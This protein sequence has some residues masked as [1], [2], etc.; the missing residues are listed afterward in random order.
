MSGEPPRALSSEPPRALGGEPASTGAWRVVTRAARD[1][2]GEGLLWSPRTQALF[3]T[4]IIGRKLWR[5]QP[6][7]GA[8]DH[9]DCPEMIGWVVERAGGG[10]VAGLQSGFHHLDLDP[11]RLAPIADPEPSLPGNRLNDAK[12][13]ERG[14]IWAGTMPV[15]DGP[16]SGWPASGG[17]YRLDPD[18][19]VTQHDRGLTIANGPAFSPDGGLLYHT[20]SARGVVYRFALAADGHLGRRQVHLTFDVATGAPDGMTCDRDGGLWI[21]FYG[22]SR[23]SRFHPDGRLDRS[24]AL[25]TPQLTN[26]VF[27]G[28]G[29]DRMFVTSAGDGRADDPLAGALFE[30]DA[31]AVGLAAHCFGG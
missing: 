10:F 29:L 15:A 9:W 12:A 13:D 14:R 30:V 27:A 8:I 24:I 11:F 18:G 16:P 26:V 20:D 19:A 28:P 25:P 5:L 3:W 17:L 2:L 6:E 7:S 23:V 1:T 31:G 4:D 21:A 22:G